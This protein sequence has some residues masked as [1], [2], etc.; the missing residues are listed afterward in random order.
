[1]KA[2]RLLKR[3][4]KWYFRNAAESYYWY[5]TGMCPKRD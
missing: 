3:V 2:L 4:A 5:P 1:M